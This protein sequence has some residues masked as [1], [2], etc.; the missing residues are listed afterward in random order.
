MRKLTDSADFITAALK[1]NNVLKYAFFVSETEKREFNLEHGSFSLFR[2]VLGNHCTITV[3]M[4][5]RKGSTSGND[6]SEEGL[7]KLVE[8]A[9][10]AAQSAVP[11]PMQDI[12]PMQG[13]ESFACG[14]R[15]PDLDGLF[16]R[17]VELKETIEKDYPLIHVMLMMTS[18]GTTHGLYCNSN[19]T[20]FESTR[21]SY[22]VTFE[23]AA[24]DGE[25][26]TG[27]DATGFITDRLDTPFIE[28]CSIRKRLEET[29]SRLSLI[30]LGEKFT[31]TL[32]LTP[33]CAGQFIGMV[34]GNYISDG[35]ILDG[36]SLWLSKLHKQVASPSL[37]VALCPW[38]SRMV[39]PE[40]WT[41]D[42]YKAEDVVLID[43]GILN[44]FLIGLYVAN[45]TG[46]D[47]TKNEGSGLI[48]TPGD[49][50]IDD[51]IA[52]IDRGLIMGSFSGGNPGTNGDFSGVAKNAF[53]IEKGKIK[54]AVS[55]TMVS[56]N[57]GEMLMNIRGI[58][59]E[60]LD[61]G[62]SITPYIAADGIVISGK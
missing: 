34:V 5:G 49:R 19:G 44:S 11:D 14:V 7:K 10:L 32:V 15:E 21:G 12:A 40:R 42:G 9:I 53:L 47:V 30:D 36:T 60:T 3:Y 24:G 20:R 41:S 2:S 51:I 50:S 54:G 26:T 48:I 23:Y 29:V 17:T 13:S 28:R 4:D 16:E 1:E 35:V 55:E 56:G 22:S 6:I 39:S 58:S 38:D 27:M 37:S 46:N 45:K 59:K 18:A 8:D 43:H 31:G 57:L 61:D 25:K 52:G 62:S 33:D